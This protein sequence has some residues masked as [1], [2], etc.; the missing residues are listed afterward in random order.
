MTEFSKLPAYR[1][2]HFYQARSSGLVAVAQLTGLII[3]HG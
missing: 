3:G 1:W 2:M